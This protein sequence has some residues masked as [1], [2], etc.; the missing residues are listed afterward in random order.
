MP[1]RDAGEDEVFLAGELLALAE[2]GERHRDLVDH[3]DRPGSP[4]LRAALPADREAPDDARRLCR[5]VDLAP[6]QRQQL[7]HAQARKGGGE[8]DCPLHLARR[9]ADER[10][11]LRRRQHVDVRPL[12]YARSLHERHRVGRKPIDLHRALE[13]SVQNDQVLLDR[14]VR[15][16]KAGA[17]P[18]DPLGSEELEPRLAELLVEAPC[19]VPVVGEGA[20]LHIAIVL[21]VPQPLR[22]RVSERRRRRRHA[23]ER[24]ATRIG[25]G[26]L[27]R[28]PSHSRGEVAPGRTP[29][30]VPRSAE[31]AFHVPAVCEAVPQVV[32][33]PAITSAQEHVTAHLRDRERRPHRKPPRTGL[34]LLSGSIRFS[35]SQSRRSAPLK[36]T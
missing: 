11:Y 20:R 22:G 9:R 26:R 31:P 3:R 16:R 8:Q 5:E 27:E 21:H 14:P 7:A 10:A 12:A 34:P 25:Q 23:G 30:S 33:A 1:A 29:A 2:P 17:P 4:R 32:D 15:T 35:R 13:D 24:S 18:F 19:H 36:R 6:P 28:V